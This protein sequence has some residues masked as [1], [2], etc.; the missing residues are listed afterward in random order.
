MGVVYIAEDSRLDRIV[1]LKILAH[2]PAGERMLRES[3]ILARLEH[4]GIV[5]VH[6][7]GTLPD[8]RVYCAMKFVR[9]RRLDDY[10]R[11]ESGPADRLRIF[12]R[13]CDTVA[14]AH[15]RGVIHRDLKPQNIMIG[16]FG[17][18]L[19]LDWGAAQ[20]A[21]HEERQ[22]T[23]IGTEGF[24]APEQSAGAMVTA[25]ADVFAL[26]RLLSALIVEPPK[27]LRAITARA[28]QPESAHRYASV[29]SMARDVSALLDGRPVMAYD[30][31][32]LER[33]G[34]YAS[35]HRALLSLI[36]AYLVLRAAFILWSGR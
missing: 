6:D 7:A 31:N 19:V 10:A 24:M 26:G 15:S 28:T 5:P 8:G 18:V 36:A 16:E 23:V 4:P 1:A 29:E 2:P 33:A 35:R 17:E 32:L 34:R 12:L 21:D 3:R 25:A 14:F 20:T 22:G 27:R 30:E 11:G 9:G 13:I